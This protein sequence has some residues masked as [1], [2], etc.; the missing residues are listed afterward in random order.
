MYQDLQ[1]PT[2]IDIIYFLKNHFSTFHLITPSHQKPGTVLWDITISG[3][4][5]ATVDTVPH[6][7]QPAYIKSI[8]DL[9]EVSGSSM[10]DI[11][12]TSLP[13]LNFNHEWCT[14]QTYDYDTIQYTTNTL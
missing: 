11:F 10:Y 5:N 1:K 12:E 14:Q 8:P 2:I 6:Q 3:E 4:A 7:T 9:V 13:M